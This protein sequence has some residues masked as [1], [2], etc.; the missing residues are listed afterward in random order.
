MGKNQTDHTLIMKK[1][2][3]GGRVETDTLEDIDQRLIMLL[4]D[5][6]KQTRYV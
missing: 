1:Q 5:T 2:A 3:I 4:H 6:K